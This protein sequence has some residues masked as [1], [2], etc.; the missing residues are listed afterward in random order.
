MAKLT[1]G[2]RVAHWRR[3]RGIK[4]ID[5]ANA[6]GTTPSTLSRI[7][8]GDIGLSV[9]AAERIARALRT[10]VAE[11]FVELDL[12]GNEDNGEWQW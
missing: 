4:Q 2:E 3:L 8:S 1:P 6:I 5:L 12:G 11:F 9:K 7:E 10:S